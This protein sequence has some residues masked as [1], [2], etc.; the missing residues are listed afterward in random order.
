[1]GTGGGDYVIS[2][3]PSPNGRVYQ[4]VAPD[5]TTGTKSGNFA[6]VLPLQPPQQKQM[7]TAGIQYKLKNNGILM[8][9]TGLSRNDLNRYS[10][11]DDND[12]FGAALKVNV[13]QPIPLGVK[14]TLTPFGGYESSGV[15]FR[16]LDPYRN[17]EFVRDW[18]LP[19]TITTSHEQLPTMGLRIGTSRKVFMQYQY[20]G[21]FRTGVYNGNRHSGQLNIDSSGWKINTLVSLL[22]AKDFLNTTKFIRP[23][24]TV[25]RVVLKKVTGDWGRLILKT[26]MKYATR[27]VI[28]YDSIALFKTGIPHISGIIQRQR[29]VQLGFHQERPKLVSGNQFV[30]SEKVQEWNL[31]GH[32]HQLENLKL[33]YTVRHRDAEPLLQDAGN[34]SINLLGRLD[35]RADLIKKAIKYSAGYEIGNG[36]EPKAEF[37][38]VKV[39]KGDGIY[40]WVDDG[41]GV[42]EVNEF[43]Q[44]PFSD[45]GNTLSL[46][47]LIMN[48]FAHGHYIFNNL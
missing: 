33:D 16:V 41:D 44:A 14:W 18:N 9:E 19:Q 48:L 40:I 21:L 30:L 39:P 25:E 17:P 6:P 47:Y 34:R 22:D 10:P 36:Q 2:P 32:F 11:V 8:A 31:I 20:D 45:Q 28:P 7:L 26:A 46:V 23:S 12:N 37:K 35:L 5:Q 4:W 29:H 27:E 38:Y 3:N 42:E 1:M 24:F 13:S 43:E 15:N